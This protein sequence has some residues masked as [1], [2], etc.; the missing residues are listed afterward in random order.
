MIALKGTTN[1]ETKEELKEYGANEKGKDYDELLM[2]SFN[3]NGT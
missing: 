1:E 2:I 3:S